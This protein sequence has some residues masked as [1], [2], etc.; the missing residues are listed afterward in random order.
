MRVERI[1]SE[2]PDLPP[3][4]PAPP[5]L[6]RTLLVL[7][8][9]GI[10]AM[11]PLIVLGAVV[12]VGRLGATNPGA[13]FAGGYLLC[14]GGLFVIIVVTSTS[15]GLHRLGAHRLLRALWIVTGVVVVLVVSSAAARS[16]RLLA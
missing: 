3:A 9:F 7:A 14:F 8:V 6:G 4:P 11:A 5:R 15:L 16:G 10:G 13:A 2:P 1:G 12:H